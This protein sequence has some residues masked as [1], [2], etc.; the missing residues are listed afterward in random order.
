MEKIHCAASK[1]A[2]NQEKVKYIYRNVG[3]QKKP[4]K[5]IR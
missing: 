1:A 5:L 3:L 2:N 4:G